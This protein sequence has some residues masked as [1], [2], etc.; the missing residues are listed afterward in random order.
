MLLSRVSGNLRTALR[1]GAAAA[2]LRA[3]LHNTSR[4]QELYKFTMPAMS[5]T[6]DEGGIASWKKNVGDSFS[7]GD[8]LLEI[9][10]DKATMEVEAQ[11]DGVLAKIIR[12]PGSKNVPVNSTIAIMAEEGDDLSGADALAESAAKEEQASG[13]ASKEAESAPE[14]AP[15]PKEKPAEKP[16]KAAPKKETPSGPIK[17][18]AATPIARRI[19]LERGI[20]LLQI[21]GSGPDGRIIK[22][23]VEK[24]VPSA[25]AA[26][27]SASGSAPAAAA[28]AAA[29]Y[30]DVPVS[31]MRRTIARRLT[32]SKQ[33]VPDYYVTV[34][35]DMGKVTQLREVFN[36]AA[37]EA[38]G[39]DKEKAKAAKLSVGDF[40]TKASA[41]AL[42]QVPEINSAWHGEFIREHHVQDISIAVATP[43]GLITPIVRNAGT[44][45]LA[46][47]SAVT[48]ELARKAR[49]GKLQPAEY[50]GGTFT[51][52]NMGMMGVSHFTAI[53]NP[54]Q[55]CILA[56]G[57]TQTR[58]VPDDS[59]QGWRKALIMQATISA[60]H[61]VADG[62][63]A[64]R[65]MQAFK[66]ALENP[67]SFML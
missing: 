1:S 49:D 24:Y 5:P 17:Q 14:P 42:R 18:I 53:I 7:A 46:E 56:I 32:E 19:A 39:G 11:N 44:S 4:V 35:V 63:T 37:V 6:M 57:A 33:T 41:I 31:N 45:G 29:T 47:I 36:R 58:I 64:A 55:S 34:E 21:K 50:Q 59:E 62:A 28:T 30:T 22:E 54:P 38:A 20:P 43:S 51:I 27:A 23:D 60:D 67:L 65:W 26:G 16:A 3:Q 12:G 2:S 25:P 52:S 13:S 15:A 10:T 8:V 48:K 40:I 61:R 66:Q 9:E